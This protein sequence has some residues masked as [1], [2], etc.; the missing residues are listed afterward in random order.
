[1]FKMLI[2]TCVWLDIAK[3]PKQTPVLGVVEEMVRL[4]MV[5]LIVPASYSTSSDGTGSVSPRKAP[6]ACPRT[7]GL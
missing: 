6:E 2:D 7:S 4:G 3:D 1:M 5:A